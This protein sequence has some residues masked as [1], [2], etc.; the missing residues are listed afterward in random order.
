M[1]Y[2]R[3]FFWGAIISA[4]FAL[5]PLIQQYETFYHQHDD[6]LPAAD[7]KEAW[8]LLIASGVLFGL[9]SLAFVRAFDEPPQRALFYYFKH[10]Q[11]D[12]LLGAWLFLLGTAPAV[13]YSFVFFSVN[14]SITYMG[15]IL[16]SFMFLFGCV[17]FV[18]GC[19]PN[20]KVS[21]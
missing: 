21:L 17:L 16:V 20:E 9:G 15:M 1:H 14:P 11:S 18:L 4:V 12:E 2:C 8:G 10:L 3:W 5:V 6:L 13:P 19:Y 7:F